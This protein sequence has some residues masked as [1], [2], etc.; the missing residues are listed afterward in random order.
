MPDVAPFRAWRYDLARAGDLSALIAPPYDVISPAQQRD[1]YARG[2]YNVVRLELTAAEAGDPVGAEGDRLRHARALASFDAWRFQGILR[3][4]PEPALYRYTQDYA[5]G[6]RSV[7]LTMLLAAV[8]LYPWSDGQILRH[9]HT[10]SRPKEERLALLRTLR[11]N[12]S[13]I[14]SLYEDPDGRVASLLAGGEDAAGQAQ[15]AADSTGVRHRVTPIVEQRLVQALVT[16]LADRPFFIADGHHRYETALTYQHEGTATPAD[17]R[18]WVLMALTATGDP[19]LRVLATHRII[20]G[21][22]AERLERLPAWFAAHARVQALPV[23]ADP[24]AFEALLA[25]EL[26]ARQSTRDPHRVLVLGPDPAALRLVYLPH[27]PAPA[28][29]GEAALQDL[30]VW[31]AHAT[32]LEQGLGIGAE[33]LARQANLQYTR[34]PAEAVAAL[35]AGQAQLVLFLPPTPV[36]ALVAVARAGGVMPQKSTYFTPKPATGLVIR[37]LVDD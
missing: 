14:W 30:D 19:G 4:D 12:V 16:A 8:R 18:D 15:E 35:R 6:A 34:D 5:L 11:A 31:L 1:L 26:P 27:P 10:L 22:D 37:R 3:Q 13:P 33:S 29:A 20:S 24:R 36:S 25:R 21:V 9:E 2:P 23:P 28:T 32:L 7:Q 17:G